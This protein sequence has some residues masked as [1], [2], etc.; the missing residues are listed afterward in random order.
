[1][2]ELID[3]DLELYEDG[4]DATENCEPTFVIVD[5]DPV[6]IE[7]LRCHLESAGYQ[8]VIHTTDPKEAADLIDVEQPDVVL[9]D[10]VMPEIDGIAILKSI[11]ANARTAR[12]PVLIM[13]ASNCVETRGECLDAGATD[14]LEKPIHPFELLPR[15][16]N[17]LVVKAHQD[18]LERHAAELEL[19]VAMRTAELS[20]AQ[21]EMVRCLARASEYRDNETGLHI[22]RVGRYSVILAN[23]LGLRDDYAEDL[24]QAAQLHD[25]GKIAI[26]DTVL[27]KPGKLTPDEFDVVKAH[28]AAGET[29]LEPLGDDE[30][31]MYRSHTD[32]G[33]RVLEGGQSPILKLAAQI[34]RNHHERWDGTGYPEGR[35]GEEIPLSGRI[36]ALADVFDAL[37][38]KRVYKEAFPFD[39]SCDIIRSESGKHFDPTVVAA[40]V[41]SIE[42]FKIIYESLGEDSEEE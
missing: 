17:A 15:I 36:V 9:L 25:I 14:F 3:V 19:R 30:I 2:A 37:T 18:H 20:L 39:R 27:C 11:R 4:A 23:Q 12:L 31:E 13:T 6:N 40:F 42:D 7:V 38:T 26:P 10:V 5:D 24:G 1:M 22:L 41:E 34:A 35:S 8:N 28:S 16:R 21:R 33:A 29:I 32:I